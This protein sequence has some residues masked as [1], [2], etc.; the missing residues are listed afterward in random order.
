MFTVVQKQN[1]ASRKET[2]PC[3]LTLK[4]FFLMEGIMTVMLVHASAGWVFQ[5]IGRYTI[6]RE[7]QI[8]VEM[9][10]SDQA[11]SFCKCQSTATKITL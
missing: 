1:Y 9:R 8:R 5:L 4:I 10:I 3:N 2:V 7:K 11:T 6:C